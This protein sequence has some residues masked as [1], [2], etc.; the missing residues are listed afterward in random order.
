[1]EQ[2]VDLLGRGELIESSLAK[3]DRHQKLALGM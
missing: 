1:V 3:D 2:R